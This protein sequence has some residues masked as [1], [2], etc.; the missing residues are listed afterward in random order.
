MYA[1]AN[2]NYHIQIPSR[3]AFLYFG[4]SPRFETFSSG[5]GKIREGLFLPF[6][7]QENIGDL[8]T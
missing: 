4:E 8:G 1:R 5:R 7:L 3:N 6:F 2:F